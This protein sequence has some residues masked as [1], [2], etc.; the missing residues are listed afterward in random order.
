MTL[1]TVGWTSSHPSARSGRG[2][3]A[4]AREGFESVER[5]PRRLPE[6]VPLQIRDLRSRGRVIR[7]VLA[8]EEAILQ[9]EVG[10]EPETEPL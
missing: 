2:D 8:G 5:L 4:F 1:A 3:V 10:D 6:Q 7:A 9:R